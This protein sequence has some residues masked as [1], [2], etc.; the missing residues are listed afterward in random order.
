M[1]ASVRS[2]DPRRF[3]LLDTNGV[4]HDLAGQ[5]SG[6]VLA[7]FF[8]S[9]CLTCMMTFPYLERLYQAYGKRGLTVWGVSQDT[10]D[11]SLAFASDQG[12]TFPILLDTAWE[13]SL[14][15]EVETVPTLF[16]F[17]SRGQIIH[18]CASFF[19]DDL[20]EIARQVAAQT[21]SDPVVIAP[22]DDGKPRFKPG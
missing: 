15:Y 9:T 5:S 8:K 14:A 11:E 7:A 3:V 2:S 22:P 13:A 18:T 16:L 21:K 19:K 4:P 17:D 6:P 12:A 1:S 20:N 10:L